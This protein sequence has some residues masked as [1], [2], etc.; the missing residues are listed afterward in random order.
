EDSKQKCSCDACKDK[1]V[2]LSNLKAPSLTQRVNKTA[3]AVIIGWILFG[4]L[5]YKVS[6]VEV[7]I[8]VWDPYEILG[9]SE[10][11]SSDQIKK[12]YKKLSLQWHPDKAPEDQKAEHEIKF[13]DITKAYK[14]LTDDDIRK[15]YEEWGHPDGKQ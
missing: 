9:I 8:E 6:T 1:Y 4:Y 14:V 11:A 2:R 7:D 12:V 10:G 3:V 15:N 13:I 5:T